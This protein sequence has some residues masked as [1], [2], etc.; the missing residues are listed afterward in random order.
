MQ[1]LKGLSQ[2]AQSSRLTCL[3]GKSLNPGSASESPEAGGKC[4]QPALISFAHESELGESSVS[5]IPAKKYSKRILRSVRQ[6]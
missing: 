6:G 2:E 5:G 1:F 4:Q 3:H